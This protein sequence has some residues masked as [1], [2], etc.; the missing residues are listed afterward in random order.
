MDAE[1][2]F[3][4][5][6]NV[7]A[8]SYKDIF[9]LIKDNKLWLGHSISSGDVEFKLPKG[10]ADKKSNSYRVDYLGNEYIK[11]SGIRWYT[12]ILHNKRNKFIKC[13]SEKHDRFLKY[14]NFDGIEIPSVNSIPSDYY[15]MMGVPITFLDKYNPNQ[16]EIIGIDRYTEGNKT[17]NKRFTINGKELYAKIVIKHKKT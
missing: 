5:L 7:N 11:V 8:I 14:D 3:I 10:N 9:S 13:S 17:P 6:G 1:K 12:N 15:G 4:I 2:Q 16:F